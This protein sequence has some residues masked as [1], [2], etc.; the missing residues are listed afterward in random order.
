MSIPDAVLNLY[1]LLLAQEVYDWAGAQESVPIYHIINRGNQV[2]QLDD[3]VEQDE[4]LNLVERGGQS[5]VLF[6]LRASP[7]EKQSQRLWKSFY[8][9]QSEYETKYANAFTAIPSPNN[10]ES[11]NRMTNRIHNHIL[12]WIRLGN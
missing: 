1:V 10:F 8:L 4:T 9:H 6:K 7:R 11:C 12:V 3:R 5:K 2:I